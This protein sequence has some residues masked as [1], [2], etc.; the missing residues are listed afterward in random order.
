MNAAYLDQ[1]TFTYDF[2][3]WSPESPK[4]YKMRI[5][6][7]S[8]DEMYSYFGMRS[9]G[10]MIDE[11]GIQRLTLNG[12]PYFFNGV[13]DQGYWS[14]GMLTYPSDKAAYAEL[15]LLKDMGF[16]TVRKHIKLEPMRWY[17]HCD[18]LGLVVWQDFPNGGGAYKYAHIAVQPFLGFHHRDDDYAYFAREKEGGRIAFLRMSEE[19]LSQLYN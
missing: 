10:R 6:N 17:Y 4:L 19:I 14:D 16:N 15:K 1:V 2:E 12:K 3:P 5:T 11:K 9:F 7:A 8:G 13:L 18:R